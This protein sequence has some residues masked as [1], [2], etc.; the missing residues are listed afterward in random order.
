MDNVSYGFSEPQKRELITEQLFPG[1]GF[2]NIPFVVSLKDS[3]DF[4]KLEKAINLFI[5]RHDG[6]RLQVVKEDKNFKQRISPPAERKFDF[7]D[8][9][10]DLAKEKFGEWIHREKQKPFILTGSDLFYFALLKLPDGSGGFFVNCHHILCDGAS[11]KILINEIVSLYGQLSRNEQA[12]TD[13]APSYLEF[14]SSEISYLRSEEYLNDKKFWEEKY[15]TLPPEITH[16]AMRDP[17]PNIRAREKHIAL[18]RRLSDKLLE[19]ANTE[20]ITPVNFMTAVIMAYFAKITRNDEVVVGMLT[21]NRKTEREKQT[22]GMFANVF[23]L[24]MTLNPELSFRGFIRAL[25]EENRLILKNH[26]RYPF[27]HLANDLRKKYKSVPSLLNIIIA[28]QDFGFEN[29]EAVYHHPLY[30]QPPYCMLIN[31]VKNGQDY[32]LIITTPEG[33]YHESDIALA[34]GHLLTAFDAVL[35]RPDRLLDDLPLMSENEKTLLFSDIPQTI[36]AADTTTITALFEEQAARTPDH[37]AL[38]FND[39]ILTYREFNAKANAL[40]WKLREEGI[41]KGDVVAI[42]MDH[43]PEMITGIFGILKSGA[44]YLPIDPAYPDERIA[45][46]IS[47]SGAK[48]VFTV[49]GLKDKLPAKELFTDLCDPASYSPKTDNPPILNDAKDLIYI[50]YTSGSTGRPKGVMISHANLVNVV[51]WMKELCSA[52]ENDRF[53]KFAGYAFDVSQGEIYPPLISGAALHIIP[54]DVRHSP[55]M[56]NDYFNRKQITVSFLPTQFAEQFNEFEENTSLRILTT[57]GDKLKKFTPRSYRFFNLYGPTECTIY[58][59][60]FEVEKSENNIPIGK[61]VPNYRLYV[62]DVFNNLMPAGVPGELCI[63]GAGVGPGYYKDPEKTAKAFV[64]DPFFPGE[65]MYRSGDLVKRDDDGNIVFLGRLDFQVKIRGFRIE[66]GEIENQILTH[67]KVREVIVVDRTGANDERFL[68]GFYVAS[69][70]LDATELRSYLSGKLPDYM[71]PAFLIR[72]EQMPLNASG[73]I[74]RKAL[75]DVRQEK[76]VTAPANSAESQIAEIWQEVL[77]I[78]N[79]GTDES[80]FSIGGDSL[81]ATLVLARMEKIFGISVSYKTFF[82]SPSIRE[83]AAI[84]LAEGKS[85]HQPITGTEKVDYYPATAAQKRFF[86]VEQMEGTQTTYNIPNHFEIIGR[87]DPGKLGNV[88]DTIIS[89]HEALRTTL[90]F[91]NNEVVQVIHDDIRIKRHYYE[92]DEAG[93]DDFIRKL[94]RPFSLKK[95]PLF[96]VALIRVSDERH[97]LFWDIHHAIFDGSSVVILLEEIVK[98]Y[99]GEQPPELFIQYKDFAIWQK[100]LMESEEIRKQ[101]AFWMDYLSGELPVT[102]LPS[103]FIRPPVMDYKGDNVFLTLTEDLT[104]RLHTLA[105]THNVTLNMVMSTVY[106]IFISKYC[107]SEDILTGMGS[108]GRNHLDTGKL[109]GMFVNTLPFRSKPEGNK[110]FSAFLAEIRDLLLDVFDNQDYQFEDIVKKLAPRRDTSRN[111]LFNCGM[112]FQSMGFPELKAGEISIRPQLHLTSIARFDHLIEIIEKGSCIETRWEYRSSLFL[113]ET[114]ERMASHFENM[115]KAVCDNPD[116]LLRDIEFISELEKKTLLYTLNETEADFPRDKTVHELFSGIAG[117]HPDRI[118]LSH[119]GVNMTYRELDE[120]SNQLAHYLRTKGVG[121]ESIVAMLFDTSPEMIVSMMGIQKA[122]GCY[123]PLKPDFPKDRI[124]FMLHDS[125]ARHLVTTPKHLDGAPG[126]EGETVDVSSEEISTHPKDKPDNVNEPGDSIYII[127]TSGSTGKPKGVILEHHN[128]VRLMVN[129]KFQYDVSEQDT[130]SMFHSYCFDFSVWEIYGALLYGGRLLMVPKEVIL[131]PADFVR[132]AKKEKITVLSQTPGAFYNFIAEDLKT[133]DHDLAIRYVTFGG[134]ALKPALLK[135]WHQKYPETKLIN[136]YGIT[137]TTVHVTFKDITDYEIDN[138]ISNIGHPIPTLRTYIMDPRQKLLPVGIPGEIIVAGDGLA[139]G[140]LNR[141]DLTN[142]R[143]PMNPYIPGERIYRSGD[144]AKRLSGGEM[145]YL[146]RIDFQVKIR[147]FRLEIGEIEN[148][149]LKHEKVRKVVVI[150]K[151]NE[152]NENYLVAY[153]M[154]EEVVPVGDFRTFLSKDLPDYM[155]P[156]FFVRMDEIPLNA[157]GK[158]DKTRLPNEKETIETGTELVETSNQAEE[159]ILRAWKK[160]L[161]VERISVRDNFFDLGGD[162]LN[163]VSLACELEKNF[164]VAVNDIFKYPTIE[165]LAARLS[166][167]KQKGIQQLEILK[168]L[169]VEEDIVPAPMEGEPFNF[170]EKEVEQALADYR[171]M[172]KEIP[173]VDYSA[174]QAY[175]HILLT[176]STGYLGAYLLYELLKETACRITLV[177]RGRDQEDARRRLHETMSHYF[178]SDFLNAFPGRFVVLNGDLS[179]ERLGLDATHYDELARSADAILNPAANTKHYGVY[180]EF[181]A[182]NVASVLNLIQLS[183]DGQKKDLHHVSTLS[184]GQGVIEGKKQ[185]LFS[186]E[187]IDIGQKFPNVYVETKFEAEKRIAAARLE[188][189]NISIYRVGNITFDTLSGATQKNIEDNGFFQQ[190]RTFVNTGMV[191]EK[192]DSFDLSYSDQLA[193]AIVKLMFAT[194]CL[195]GNYHLFN[196]K[197][198]RLSDVLSGATYGLNIRRVQFP[199]F[200]DFIL[201]H[202]E[203]SGAGTLIRNYLL[204]TGLMSFNEEAAEAAGTQILYTAEKTLA[205]LGRLGYTWPDFDPAKMQSFITRALKDRMDF[206]SGIGWLNELTSADIY[207]LAAQTQAVFPAEEENILWEG[208]LN[209]RIYFVSGGHIEISK[210]SAMGWLGSVSI[211]SGSD[212]FGEES[213]LDDPLSSVNADTI[214]GDAVLLSFE[215]GTFMKMLSDN[216]RLNQAFIRAMIRKKSGLQGLFVNL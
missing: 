1:T 147:G 177:V 112:I 32:Y 192:Y 28:G 104:A 118:A 5:Q 14:L 42:L 52:G 181:F 21:H 19:F 56:V 18:S 122:G 132:L 162:S 158:V 85:A 58:S 165:E 48:K 102:D 126:F 38:V 40:A 169:D 123:L 105:S 195:N 129:S 145:E 203:R 130:W 101:E 200:I 11:V 213:L 16:P 35:S 116:V 140:Y 22:F 189:N 63:A 138:N 160:V 172:V 95:A 106:N 163:A 179:A 180:E 31:L 70:H 97:I 39:E 96:R 49:S 82:K 131:N 121:R 199:E 23:P 65:I 44:A 149:L 107:Q 50:I 108:S 205:V 72:L 71:I 125:G 142:E 86:M 78:K 207:E 174:R 88:V 117:R 45:Y 209:N 93:A 94:I 184:V 37:T 30:E 161:E 29:C 25:S 7:F 55:K 103:D 202:H 110:S 98:L 216:G 43:R 144:L 124:E 68:A 166:P 20:G 201:S 141:E 62:L 128:V 12:A 194:A 2:A 75:P 204:H 134:E 150:A 193:K 148:H 54:P 4:I 26:S 188:G 190:V 167:K 77:G 6:I 64:P 191:P 73:K 146:G 84:I 81:T 137:E 8:F 76:T 90:D 87:L 83:L 178:G 136:M 187:V 206:F 13:P 157:N 196:P 208:S 27:G 34:G 171:K 214:L 175:R 143:F 41:G 127:Y 135:E 114:V 51:L 197:R 153:Y 67:E 120:R 80:F 91:V 215:R 89:R 61:A 92:A 33:M 66:I 198:V 210:H 133:S 119:H 186:E 176:G 15:A 139:R 17:K 57:G 156:S 60:F 79:F 168:T 36:P 211:L 74:D 24:R 173:A 3:V 183:R 151:K 9:S 59:T 113:K 185:G 99:N 69:G 182:T 155:I 164:E 159:T 100:K 115:L 152:S 47:E 53:S 111:P 170:K 212:F 46:I 10:S 109:I 154:S